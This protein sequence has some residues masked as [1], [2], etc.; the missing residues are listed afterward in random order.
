MIAMLVQLAA[1]VVAKMVIPSIAQDI[2]ANKGS[3]GFFLGCLSLAVGVLNA[4]CMSY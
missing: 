1:F 3:V 2:E 4:A